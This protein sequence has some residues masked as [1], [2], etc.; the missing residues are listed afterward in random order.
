[1]FP[2]LSG[3]PLELFAEHSEVIRDRIANVLSARRSYERQLSGEAR[4]RL[5]PETLRANIARCDARLVR[6]NQQL[7]AI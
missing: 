1:M 6:L 4:T 2:S 3:L 5:K 7:T